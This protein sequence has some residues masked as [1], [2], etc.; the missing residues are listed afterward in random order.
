MQNLIYKAIIPD[1]GVIASYKRIRRCEALLSI[2]D[3]VIMCRD[4]RTIISIAREVGAEI[5]F[6]EGTAVPGFVDAHMHIDSLGLFLSSANL[7]STFSREEL[8]KKIIEGKEIG[9]W[10]IGRGFD[11]NLFVDDKKPPTIN[12]LDLISKDKPIFIIHRSGHMGAV[13]SVAL[14]ILLNIVNDAAAEKIDEKN[15][16]IYEDTV[17]LLYNYIIDN[18]PTH[19]YEEILVKSVNHI[20]ENGVSAVGVA[21]CNWKCLDALKKL[22]ETG[23]LSIRTYVYMFID[24]PEEIDKVAREAI[25]SRI[26]HNKLRINGIKIILDGA[27]GTRTAYLSEPY[28]DDQTNKGMLLYDPEYLEEIM[29]RANNHGLQLAIH[30]IGDA[31]LDQVL[32]ILRKI[33]RDTR[34]IRHRIEHASLIRDDQLE[35]IDIVKPIVVVQPGF[36]LSD[37]WLIDRLGYERIKWVYRF[38]SLNKRTVIALSTDSPVEPIDP[39]VTIYAA[40]SRG[41]YE[42]LKHGILT[43]SEKIGLIDALYAY[44]RGSAYALNDEKLGCLYEGCYNDPILLDRDPTAIVDLREILSLKIKPL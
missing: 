1:K 26:H 34:I 5:E 3:Q 32:R 36:V 13:N 12:D 11:H 25:I 33:I 14:E 2:N 39:R 9:G 19:A 41:V 8:M 44:T 35:I 15:G 20:K 28:S 29:L 43:A 37:K 7:N 10:I 22:D 30:C 38:K 40:V 42:G 27:L 6:C 31:C 17:M 16:W 4:K 24:K 21:G 23:K 18:L